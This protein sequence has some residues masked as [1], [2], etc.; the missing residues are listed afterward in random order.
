MRDSGMQVVASANF[1]QTGP[2]MLFD[3]FFHRRIRDLR[4]Y[5]QMEGLVSVVNRMATASDR[6]AARVEQPHQ[7]CQLWKVDPIQAAPPHTV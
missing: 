2:W 4:H 5:R 7:H 6:P 1:G 3:F